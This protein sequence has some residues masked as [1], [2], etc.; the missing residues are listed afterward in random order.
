MTTSSPPA[1]D[2]RD[3]AD[4]IARVRGRLGL[5][6]APLTDAMK[7]VYGADHGVFVEEIT[8]ESAAQKAGFQNEDVIVSFQGKDVT[9]QDE[10]VNAVQSTR[11]GTKVK[12]EVLRNGKRMTLTPTVESLASVFPSVDPKTLK[13]DK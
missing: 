5:M 2:E 10:F 6:V 4:V 1:I 11:P 3:V 13:P 8:K 12:V 9:A 7:H